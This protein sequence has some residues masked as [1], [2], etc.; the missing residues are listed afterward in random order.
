MLVP[1]V[2]KKTLS[3]RPD[4]HDPRDQYV[5]SCS[6]TCNIEFTFNSYLNVKFKHHDHPD[7]F[8]FTIVMQGHKRID[9]PIISTS[10]SSAPKIEEVRFNCIRLMNRGLPAD[11][12]VHLRQ[13]SL[14]RKNVPW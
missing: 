7:W 10:G 1:P 14:H 13:F 12:E 4:G 3:D 6:L 2:H 9:F 8:G 11:T 5:V